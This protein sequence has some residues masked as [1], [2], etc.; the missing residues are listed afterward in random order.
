M[1]AP[2]AALA[3]VPI[4]IST[5][6]PNLDRSR[7]PPKW[8]FQAFHQPLLAPDF[9]PFRCGDI[10]VPREPFP[11]FSRQFDAA[12]ALEAHHVSIFAPS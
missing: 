7:M 3:A 1:S 10:F 5:L 2:G 6:W 8:R 12:R 4:S 9:T 11:S